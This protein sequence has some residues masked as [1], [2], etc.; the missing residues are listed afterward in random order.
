MLLFCLRGLASC[1]SSFCRTLTSWDSLGLDSTFSNFTALRWTVQ[2]PGKRSSQ[3][4]PILAPAW[5]SGF[6]LQANL[7]YWSQANLGFTICYPSTG[8]NGK[9]PNTSKLGPTSGPVPG[10]LGGPK[11]LSYVSGHAQPGSGPPN[12]ISPTW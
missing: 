2:D 5:H 1:S 12:F 4:L 9:I 7:G 3:V 8:L 10:P 6:N 11:A